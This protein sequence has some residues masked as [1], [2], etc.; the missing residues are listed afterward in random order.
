MALN[1]NDANWFRPMWR[2]VSITVFLTG[3][4]L[5][6]ILWNKDQFWAVLVGFAFLYSLFNFFY[7]FPKEEPKNDNPVQPSPPPASEDGPRS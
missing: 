2:R 7:A 1:G 4:L 5:W 3:W 6:E